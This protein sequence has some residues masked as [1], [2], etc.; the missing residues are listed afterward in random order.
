MRVTDWF[1]QYLDCCGKRCFRGEKFQ[2]APRPIH[3]L[4]RSQRCLL[5]STFAPRKR[6]YQIPNVGLWMLNRFIRIP[7][8]EYLVNANWRDEAFWRM[9]EKEVLMRSCVFS[10]K[11]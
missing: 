3:G 5:L 4:H 8:K 6:T 7:R 1:R 9:A 10:L 2:A 11:G